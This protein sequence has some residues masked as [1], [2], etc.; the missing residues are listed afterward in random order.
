VSVFT[1]VAGLGRPPWGRVTLSVLLGSL[2]VLCGVGLMGV[3]G[4]VISRAAE[5]PPILSLTVAIVLI[6][7]FALSRPVSRYA[8]RLVSH[9]LA[10]RVLARIRV[11]FYR[12]L[13]P[14]VPARTGGRRSG[15]L[16]AAMVADVD[17]MQ[18]LFLRGLTP[19]LIAI[20]SGVASV[21]VIGA[22]LPLA[23]LILLVGLVIGG[24]AVPAAAARAARSTAHRQVATAAELTAELVEVLR[25]A[26][27]LVVLGADR[28]AAEAIGAL[29]A[30]L[31]RMR[32]RDAVWGGAVE[33]LATLVSGL[34]TVGVLLACTAAADAGRL[35]RVLVAALTLGALAAFEAVAPLA[36]AGATVHA[37]RAAAGRL[38]EVAGR[39]PAVTDPAAPLPDPE[40]SAAALCRVD[41]QYESGSDDGWGLA[42]VDL[43][44][45]PGRA[46]A[47]MG[48]SGSGKSTVAALLV[49]FADPDGGRVTVGVPAEDVRDL[50]QEQVRHV[51]GLDAQD[52]YLFET[53]IAENV[54]LARPAATD[55]D[56]EA[57]L[58]AAR[59]W[60]WVRTLPDGMHTFVGA[61]GAEVSGGER[62][63]IAL[64]RAFLADTP[65]LVLD[66]PT[67]HLDPETARDLLTDALAAAGDRSVLLITHRD[68]GLEAVDEVVTLRR[69][70]VQAPAG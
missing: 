41:F 9:D 54:R 21:I 30:E 2:T 11:A 56:I 31:L 44:V 33:G 52:A 40:G 26:P 53:T 8:E 29:D 63:R 55:E 42:D 34:T 67:A 57:A 59:V 32:S 18:N 47:L 1:D 12:R 7:T 45:E 22:F 60:D 65:V 3:A 25:S 24:T 17:A 5:H 64:A 51:V 66:E 69:G 48:P 36:N 43:A 49:R 16:L 10:F 20:V 4:Y 6:R 38:V 28:A 70:R 37:T 35:D 39:R 58:R 50:T 19:A 68:E 14:L 61:D 13:E 62:R 27:E 15:D 23:G 46:V